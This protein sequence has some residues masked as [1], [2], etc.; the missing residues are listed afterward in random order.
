M[1]GEHSF[2]DVQ[3]MTGPGRWLR[4]RNENDEC[5]VAFVVDES[6]KD[7]GAVFY[8]QHWLDGE[9]KP[10]ACTGK[11]CELCKKSDRPSWRMA[12]TVLNLETGE[13]QI[14]DGF[15][16]MWFT[17]LQDMLEEYDWKDTGF[18]IKRKGQK[19][20]TRR[21]IMPKPLTEEQKVELAMTVAFTPEELGPRTS[22][23]EPEH[24]DADAP[25]IDD[26]DLPF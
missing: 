17:D 3:E 2:N 8:G 16:A 14:L 11:G 5:F 21:N 25:P 9:K 19:A 6:D 10:V 7:Y 1:A 22:T 15:P 24:S 18:K 23:A 4:L 20:Q 13:K 12:I 26:D